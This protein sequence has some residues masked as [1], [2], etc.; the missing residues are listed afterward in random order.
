[1]ST[2]NK[3][4]VV[5]DMQQD[6]TLNDNVL[7]NEYTKAIV[8]NVVRLVNEFVDENLPVIFTLDTHSDTTYTQTREG[9]HLPIPHCL[10]GT[11]GWNLIPELKKFVD[12]VNTGE[13]TKVDSFG[14]WN[15]NNGLKLGSPFGLD[16]NSEYE[17]HIC[18]VVTN[19]CVLAVA[20]DFQ[21]LFTRSEIIIHSDCCASNDPEMHQKAL[22]IMKGLHMQVI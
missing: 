2:K 8:P 10:Y 19:M 20:L 1:M 4:L 22:D 9:R 5:V 6:F 12:N 15:L 7:G 16:P 17:I 21:N 3:F 13:I 11:E 18:G 14:F